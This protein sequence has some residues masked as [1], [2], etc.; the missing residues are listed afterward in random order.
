[1]FI[2]P[3]SSKTIYYDSIYLVFSV[4]LTVSS[5]LISNEICPE[6]IWLIELITNNFFFKSFRLIA[7]H[8]A[9]KLHENF[10]NPVKRVDL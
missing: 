5:F 1:M 2:P 8:R 9:P 3:S 4:N 6:Y 7:K 10:S